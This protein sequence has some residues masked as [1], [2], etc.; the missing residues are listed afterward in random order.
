MRRCV[1]AVIQ[2]D[3]TAWRQVKPV[4]VPS[5][6]VPSKKYWSNVDFRYPLQPYVS[7][8]APQTKR[9]S[10]DILRTMFFVFSDVPF[11]Y[12][13]SRAGCAVSYIS[14]R[15]GKHICLPTDMYHGSVR[16]ARIE[17]ECPYVL[18]IQ[19]EY[20]WRK[21]VIIFFLNFHAD[22]LCGPFG[23]YRVSLIRWFTRYI[24]DGVV[25]ATNSPTRTLSILC[26]IAI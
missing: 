25:D 15:A 19:C 12:I 18:E 10:P 16:S 4:E 22:R 3:L 24:Y 23:C 11:S 21:Y 17:Y 13:P 1:D 14:K 8:W 9:Y 7:P 20:L 6:P 26:S 2:K 5:V